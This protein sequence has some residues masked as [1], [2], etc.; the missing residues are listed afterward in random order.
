MALKTTVLVNGINNLS[1]ARYCAGMGAD[2]MGFNLEENDPK[3]LTTDA[4]KEITGWVSGIQLVGEFEEMSAAKINEKAFEL[5]LELIQLN[6]TYLI[7]EIRKIEKPVIQKV[8]INK[9]TL[10]TELL[11]ML[12]LYK[13][14]VAYFLIYSTDFTII[15]ETNI[16]LLRDLANL[17]KIIIGFGVVKQNLT[18]ILEQIKP[19]GLGLQGSD[20]I[21]PGLKTFDELEEIFEALEE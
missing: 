20:E 16:R 3:H 19:I 5:N 7:D 10:E 21:R 18:A 17:Y 9:D 4:F 11:E 8:F 13:D 12:D 2:L 1:D 14:D 15:D 6:K